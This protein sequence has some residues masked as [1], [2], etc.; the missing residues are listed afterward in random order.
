MRMLSFIAGIFSVLVI[1]SSIAFASDMPPKNSKPVSEIAASL[2]KQGY[3]PI[4][5]IEFDNGKW[6]VEAYKNGQK[7]EL[8][9]DPISGKIISNHPDH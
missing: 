8:K 7:C 5:E 4:E 9:V 1:S 3:T 2:E 6:E